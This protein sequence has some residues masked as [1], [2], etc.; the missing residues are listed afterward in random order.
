MVVI[1]GAGSITGAALAAA[2]LT[3]AAE[4]LRPVEEAANLFGASQIIVAV[5]VIL[6]LIYRPTGLFGAAEPD[7][8]FWLMRSKRCREAYRRYPRVRFDNRRRSHR[9]RRSVQRCRLRF[10]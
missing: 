2:A 6:V 4:L 9:R 5:G 1:G 3:I 7:V 8:L 10:G